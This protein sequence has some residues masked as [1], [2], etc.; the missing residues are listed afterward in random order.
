MAKAT[1]RTKLIEQLLANGHVEVAPTHRVHTTPKYVVFDVPGR[2]DFFYFVGKAGALRA[3]RI[4]SDSA[5]LDGPARDRLIQAWDYAHAKVP[6]PE[7]VVEITR[8]TVTKVT[9]NRVNTEEV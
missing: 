4:I 3:G 9:D 1:I 5:S 8:G 2:L 7:M 6:K